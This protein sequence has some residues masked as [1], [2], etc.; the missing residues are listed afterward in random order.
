M[1][2]ITT[3]KTILAD[4]EMVAFLNEVAPEAV[5]QA[6]DMIGHYNQYVSCAAPDLYMDEGDYMDAS[7]NERECEWACEE[8][9]EAIESMKA[10]FRRNGPSYFGSCG[11]LKRLSTPAAKAL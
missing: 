7:D 3:A 9:S 8:I 6:E 11:Y 1:N 4:S 2:A 5:E 10:A